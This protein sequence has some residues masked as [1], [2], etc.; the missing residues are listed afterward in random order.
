MSTSWWTIGNISFTST[1]LRKKKKKQKPLPVISVILY[2]VNFLHILLFEDVV[3][4]LLIPPP[5]F[6][7]DSFYPHSNTS[8]LSLALISVFQI[9]FPSIWISQQLSLSRDIPF[10]IP[11]LGSEHRSLTEPG[12]YSVR[13]LIP[14]I[15][16]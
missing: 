2:K 14:Q 1:F 11:S 4:Q 6:F 5:T 7:K 16:G 12:C 10:I 15:P 13:A 9:I 8:L 3:F